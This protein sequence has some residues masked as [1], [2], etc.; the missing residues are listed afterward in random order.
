VVHYALIVNSDGVIAVS[1]LRLRGVYSPMPA[2]AVV[3][4]AT[5]AIATPAATAAVAP[6]Q[7]AGAVQLPADPLDGLATI[8]PALFA[9]AGDALYERIESLVIHAAYAHCQ[10]NQVHTAALLGIS[11]NVLR[12]QLKR[13]GLL[14]DAKTDSSAD[15]DC[16]IRNTAVDLAPTEA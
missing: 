10:R 14:S 2:P 16:L 15:S 1:D 5:P 7:S 6:L 8:L 3:E 9:D 12:T 13:F 11:R 4:V